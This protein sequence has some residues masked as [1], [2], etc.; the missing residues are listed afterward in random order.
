VPPFLEIMHDEASR[1]KDK[2]VSD[3]LTATANTF[4]AETGPMLDPN[5]YRDWFAGTPVTR[6]R[7]GLS[8]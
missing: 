3:A 4:A 2:A 1:A 6:Y 7:A 8:E 5:D